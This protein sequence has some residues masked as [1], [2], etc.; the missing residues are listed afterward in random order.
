MRRAV[1]MLAAVVVVVVSAPGPAHAAGSPPKPGSKAASVNAT[2]GAAPASAKKIDGRPYFSFNAS[3]GAQLTDH[4]AITNYS[5]RTVTLNAY[6]VDAAT[7]SNGAIAFDNKNAPRRQAG[8]WMAVGTP[9]GTGTVRVKAR[10]TDILPIHILVPANAS[11]GD[12]VGA[13]IVSLNGRIT[14]SLGNGT[15]GARFEQRIA[16]RAVFRISGPVRPLLTIEGL[17]ASYSGPIDPFAKGHVTVSYVVHNAGNVVLGGPQTVS[18]HGMFGS[19]ETAP[20]L[21]AIEPL[22]PGASYAVKVR[23]PAVYPEV[24]M[25]A[26]VAVDAEG[27]QGEV[28]PGLHPATSSV[29]FFAIPWIVVV[30]LLLLILGLAGLVIRWRRRKH[31]VAPP[32]EGASP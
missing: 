28:N 24:R 10:A 18:V 8:A 11:P 16:V 9:G 2:F 29:H 12:H 17:K 3:P 25:T 14:G 6:S 27:L 22:L 4:V 13:V 7:A 21:A 26:K 1:L 30:V 19:T 20:N 15:T 23:V 31:R 5:H 32:V